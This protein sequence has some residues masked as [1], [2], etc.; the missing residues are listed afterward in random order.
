MDFVTRDAL[1]AAMHA[2]V[3]EKTKPL[4]EILVAQGALRPE[5]R[6]LLEPLVNEH[7]RQHGDDPAQSLAAVGAATTTREALKS[8]GDDDLQFS[9]G[10]LSTAP[11]DPD[12]TSTYVGA[13]TSTGGRFRILRFEAAGGLGEVFLARDEELHRE[14]ALKQIKNEHVHSQ[15]QRSRFVVEAEITGGLEHPGIV[16]VYGLGHYDDGR[17]YYAMRF[18]RGQSL[19]D[20][21]KKFHQAEGPG[22]DPTARSLA[23]RQLLR[24]FLDVCNAIQYAHDRGVLHRDLKPGNVMLGPY[25]ETL[26]V[27]WGLA[28]VV[29][30]PDPT[31][32]EETLQ[33]ASG[34]DVA[35]TMA[36]V[37]IGTLVYMS[38]EQA[39][40]DLDRLGPASDVYSLGATLYHLLTG[41]APFQ[42][43]D[44]AALKMQVIAGKFPPPRRVH[45]SVPTGLDAICRKAM[46]LRPEDRYATVRELANDLEKWLADE[47]VPGES[48]ATQVRRWFRKN[49]T[50]ASWLFAMIFVDMHLAILRMA[51]G[52]Q[53]AGRSLYEDY[54]GT[55]FYLGI[56]FQF[57]LIS[58]FIF[59]IIDISVIWAG[60]GG[61]F[62]RIY[63]RVAW[64]SFRWTVKRYFILSTLIFIICLLSYVIFQL[65]LSKSTPN[66]PPGV[67]RPKQHATPP[68]FI[69]PPGVQGPRQPSTPPAFI[70]TST[71]AYYVKQ[72]NAYAAKGESAKAVEAYQKAID[73]Y[74]KLV[75]AQP[76]ARIRGRAGQ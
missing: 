9:L 13:P 12:R 75:A 50:V 59:S 53:D 25:G 38:P 7:V 18:I 52:M 55:I 20:A 40:G 76:G 5:R 10:H 60:S 6:A 67:Q 26:V 65:G 73:G 36:G 27:D 41:Q 14:V 34:S 15:D 68:A 44:R 49:P 58:C 46:A 3:L 57:W 72:G 62:R 32:P 45:S 30:R 2:W 37:A 1:I 42:G 71:L 35:A 23:L 28:K 54:F 19:K 4:G 66:Y 47:P 61:S 8:V 22:R 63:R 43:A 64:R 31:L 39:R 69:S 29:G 74:A 24:R 21:I 17:P 33:P 70:Q 48:L 11:T 51:S 16:P 56:L